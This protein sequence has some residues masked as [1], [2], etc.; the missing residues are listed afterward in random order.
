MEGLPFGFH[1]ACLVCGYSLLFFKDFFIYSRE[2]EQGQE[3]RG[4]ERISS[5]LPAEHGA[6]CRAQ[7]QHPEIMT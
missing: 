6:Q 5:R 7:S 4:R 2:S 3:G 1:G